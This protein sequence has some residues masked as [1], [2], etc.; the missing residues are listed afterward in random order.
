MDG[1]KIRIIMSKAV[2]LG[3]MVVSHDKQ[4]TKFGVRID[5]HNPIVYHPQRASLSIGKWEEI[6]TITVSVL[7][8][9]KEQIQRIRKIQSEDAAF[10]LTL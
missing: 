3:E 9:S 4:N 2:A 7:K 5:V 1:A 8:L 10:E 6:G